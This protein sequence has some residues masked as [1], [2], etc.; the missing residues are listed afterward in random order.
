M[1]GAG[2]YWHCV[3]QALGKGRRAMEQV[4]ARGVGKGVTLGELDSNP[5]PVYRKLQ[6][7]GTV[8]WVEAVKRWMVTRW[9]DVIHVD[10][11]D[12]VFRAKETDLLQTRVIGRTMTRSDGEA[13]QRLRKAAE[14]PL[15]PKT[16]QRRWHEM[17]SDVANDLID[18]LVDRG[19]CEIMGEFAGPF[20]RMSVWSAGGILR[21][22]PADGGVPG[23]RLRAQPRRA[24]RVARRRAGRGPAGARGRRGVVGAGPAGASGAADLPLPVL[25]GRDWPALATDRVRFVGEPVAV[26]VAEDRAPP[27]Y[28][29]LSSPAGLATAG[30]QYEGRGRRRQGADRYRGEV[31]L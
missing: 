8:V 13:H 23:G 24:R 5:Y 10:T 7:T 1:V 19:E 2:R 27:A 18:G 29:R 30:R 26:V 22:E 3:G 12:E 21:R 17:L 14:E 28:R 6:D 4:S 31:R 11:N 15:R 16:V 20:A 9:D 25:E